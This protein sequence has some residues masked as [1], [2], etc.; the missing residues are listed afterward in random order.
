MAS[1]AFAWTQSLGGQAN[2]VCASPVG[3]S[4]AQQSDQNTGEVP[5]AYTISA[6][7]GCTRAPSGPQTQSGARPQAEALSS[8]LS[9][10]GSRSAWAAAP[11]LQVLQEARGASRG[12]A[13]RS[14]CAP[15]NPAGPSG[16]LQVSASRSEQPGQQHPVSRQ[17][18]R[19]AV[20]QRPPAKGQIPLVSPALTRPT[21][22]SEH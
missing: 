19:K 15:V 3:G 10:S 16:S 7:W 17:C 22:T 1:Q 9:A 21:N 18:R 2:L 6:P 4:A 12:P 8:T 14:R 11:H 5:S 20:H 13:G